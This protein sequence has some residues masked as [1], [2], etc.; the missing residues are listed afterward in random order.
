MFQRLGFCVSGYLYLFGR[1]RVLTNA[2]A[3]PNVATKDQLARKWGTILWCSSMRRTMTNR[4]DWNSLVC[5]W[6]GFCTGY[7]YTLNFRMC[8]MFEFCQCLWCFCVVFLVVGSVF[9]EGAVFMLNFVVRGAGDWLLQNTSVTRKT[10]WCYYR[11][12][13]CCSEPQISPHAVCV[14]NHVSERKKIQD[15]SWQDHTAETVTL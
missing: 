12:N 9:V 3:S 4:W 11:C 1:W 10:A 8:L 13:T 14:F 7:S 6:S 15:I 2:R 5:A